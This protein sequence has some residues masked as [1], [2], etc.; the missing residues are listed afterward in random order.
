MLTQAPK[1]LNVADEASVVVNTQVLVCT[2]SFDRAIVFTHF[3][4]DQFDDIIFLFKQF[5]YFLENTLIRTKI[6]PVTLLE[7]EGVAC[8]KRH[9]SSMRINLT[10]VNKTEIIERIEFAGIAKL[11]LLVVT[12]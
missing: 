8:S 3:K 6:L 12:V 5:S 9:A 4:E 2:D 7:A 11:L 10:L 1:E